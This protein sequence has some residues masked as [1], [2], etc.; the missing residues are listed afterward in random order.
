MRVEIAVMEIAVIHMI[1]TSMSATRII[2]HVCGHSFCAM[3]CQSPFCVSLFT[4]Y[5]NPMMW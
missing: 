4:F 1:V 2:I 3:H 5:G